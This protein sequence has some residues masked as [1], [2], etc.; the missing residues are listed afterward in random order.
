[1]YRVFKKLY[2]TNKVGSKTLSS[3]SFLIG[4]IY[5]NSK[6][7]LSLII[8]ILTVMERETIQRRYRFFVELV[9]YKIHCIEH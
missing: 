8:I 3:I 1:M 4:V 5:N 2:Y 7:V 6:S 9:R